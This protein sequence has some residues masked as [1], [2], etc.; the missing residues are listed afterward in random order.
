MS[1][2]S[3]VRRMNEARVLRCLL[4][5]GPMTRAELARELDARGY[6]DLAAVTA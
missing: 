1:M 4:E 3:T 2:P 5:N 6:G